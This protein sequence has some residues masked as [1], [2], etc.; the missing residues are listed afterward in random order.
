MS[1]SDILICNRTLPLGGSGPIVTD[2][3]QIQ[4]RGLAR[5][6]TPQLPKEEPAPPKPIEVC[7]LLS[8]DIMLLVMFYSRRIEFVVKFLN[9]FVAKSDL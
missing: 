6:I 4:D 8:A 5:P 1:T 9:F 3:T 7:Q 2:A